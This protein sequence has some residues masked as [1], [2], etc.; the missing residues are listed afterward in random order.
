M[1]ASSLDALLA[2][3]L[4]QE[5]RLV[6]PSFDNDTAIDLGLAIV[7]EARRRG[8]AVTVDVTRVGQQIFHMALPGTSADNDQW[9]ARKTAVVMRFG[10]SSY[11]MGRKAVQKGVPFH[12]A[13]LV[14]PLAYAAHGGCFPVTVAGTGLVGTVTVSG[15]PQEE[16][17]ALVVAVLERFLVDRFG[18]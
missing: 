17:H 9:V 5:R 15:L 1:T 16:D 13:H 8:L 10:H 3:L 18:G 11:Y 12:E 2:D 7:A 4:D 6:F 14:D